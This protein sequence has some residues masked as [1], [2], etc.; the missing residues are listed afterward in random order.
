MPQ[1]QNTVQSR[2]QVLAAVARTLAVEW[3]ADAQRL[4]PGD[5][6]AQLGLLAD[7]LGIPFA[8]ALDDEFDEAE[9][10]ALITREDSHGTGI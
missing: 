2:V 9:L 3:E 8:V 7:R 1:M 6:I 10:Q 4:P 5:D